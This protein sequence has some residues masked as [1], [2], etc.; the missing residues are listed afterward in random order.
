MAT[1]PAALGMLRLNNARLNYLSA[2]LVR[3]RAT[4]VAIWVGGALVT[5]RVRKS[6]L[7]IR[8]V[9]NDSPNSA[10]F[11]MVGAAPEVDQLVRITLNSDAPRLLFDGSI[12]SVT[13]SYTG[14]SAPT[15]PR[16]VGWLVRATDGT[17]RANVRLPFGS[18]TNLCASTVA[19]DIMNGFGYGFSAHHIEPNLPPVSVNLDGSEG[20]NGAMRQIAKLI[21][22]FFYWEDFDLHLFRT[23]ATE[24]PDPIDDTPGRFLDQPPITSTIDVSQLRT[25]VYGKGHGESTLSDVAAGDTAIPLTSTVMFNQAGGRAIS[26]TQQLTYG[27]VTQAQPGDPPVARCSGGV[28]LSS[29][30]YRYGYTDVTASGESLVSPAASVV[31]GLVDPPVSAPS[32]TAQNGAG[33]EDGLHHY[34]TTFVIGSGE[35]TPGPISAGVTTS[36]IPPN[37]VT[38]PGSAPTLAAPATIGNLPPYRN[39]KYACTFGTSAGETPGGPISAAISARVLI[40]GNIQVSAVMIPGG[41]LQAGQYYGWQ[42]TV[43]TAKGESTTQAS[44]SGPWCDGT[45]AQIQWTITHSAAFEPRMTSIR[46]YRVKGGGG[47]YGFVGSVGPDGGTFVDNLANGA[48]G[49]APP[50]TD[51]AQGGVLV[52]SNIP[53]SPDGRVTKRRIYRT[54]ADGSQPKFLATISDNVTTGV[55]DNALDASLGVNMPTSDTTGGSATYTQQVALAN[56]PLGDSS[57]NARRLYRRY[58]NAGDFLFVGAISDNVTVTFLD[59]TPNAYRGPAA[60]TTNSAA[61]L[62]V[63]LSALLPGPAGTIARKVYRS[64]LNGSSLKFLRSVSDNTTTSIVDAAADATLGAAPPATDTSALGGGFTTTA[65]VTAAGATSMD[66]VTAGISKATG[67]WVRIGDSAVRYTGK[68]GNTLTGIPATGP[69]CVAA[70]I[71]AGTL[72]QEASVLTGV[73]GLLRALRKGAP[74]N[75]WVQRDDVP[76]QQ[77]FAARG[78]TVDHPID[79]VLEHEI[80]DERRGEASLSAYC[81][82]DLQVFSRPIQTVTYATRDVKTKSGRPIVINLTVPPIA[83]TLTIQDVTITQ[84]DTLPGVPPRY[85]VSAS[86]MR[87]SV[88]DLLARLADTLEGQ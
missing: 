81:D 83:A 61:G 35:T 28:G 69:G 88:Q 17:A 15:R 46:I 37:P 67:G 19:L 13:S 87:F 48:M 29:G 9:L 36:S 20:M 23:E 4:R 39:Y 68:S 47:S 66:L 76:A 31:T 22:G 24:V 53:T 25:R 45:N 54:T 85:D 27:A 79:G 12:E 11:V 2:A 77:A 70:A 42:I 72:V 52:L 32:P 65:S 14:R 58:N 44:G 8:D 51:T 41:S 56:I 6:G 38:P 16:Q 63:T 50:I 60:P 3:V 75:I 84:I 49:G 30:T 26:E 55:T 40:T 71:P 18:W 62:Q 59:A 73:T 34:V 33:L 57:V 80:V 21:G 86:T 64:V 78:S 1:Q 5:A 7:T 82:A 43:T 74:V 10:T